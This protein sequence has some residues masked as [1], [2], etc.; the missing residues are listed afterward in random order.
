MIPAVCNASAIPEQ[1]KKDYH[2]WEQNREAA[3]LSVKACDLFFNNY[4]ENPEKDGKGQMFS[5]ML[6]ETGHKGLPPAYFQ[7]CGKDPLRDE[8]FIYERILREEVGIKTK[9]DAY[10]GLPHGYW[11]IFPQLEA[12]KKFVADSVEGIKWLLAQKA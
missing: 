7:I 4:M 6:W 10:G 1:Y 8:A 3:I 2:S 12:S 9:V 5:P 11:S